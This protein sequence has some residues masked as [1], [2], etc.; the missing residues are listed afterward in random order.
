VVGS[1]A[2]SGGNEEWSCAVQNKRSEAVS[3]FLRSHALQKPSTRVG[4]CTRT[5]EVAA[6]AVAAAL[7]TTDCFS[8]GIEVEIERE[9]GG[10]RSTAR[11]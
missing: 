8:R 1:G 4:G 10:A 7:D 2:F 3:A 5:E 11:E 9:P 6:L